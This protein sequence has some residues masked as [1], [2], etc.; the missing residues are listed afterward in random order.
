MLRI[1][2]TNAVSTSAM[3]RFDFGGTD[4]AHC[5]PQRSARKGSARCAR[6]HIGSGTWT[7][8]RFKHLLSFLNNMLVAYKIVFGTVSARLLHAE[9]SI[10][11]AKTSLCVTKPPSADERSLPTSQVFNAAKKSSELGDFP[12]SGRGGAAQATCTDRD[13]SA[14]NSLIKQ[15]LH[16]RQFHTLAAS[17]QT[18][19]QA[20]QRPDVTRVLAWTR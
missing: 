19:V 20:V 8:C 18:L 4:L 11:P 16:M 2:C 12:Y 6:I 7:N 15:E 9:R 5:L 14:R 17:C 3:R 1:F 10:L 13:V